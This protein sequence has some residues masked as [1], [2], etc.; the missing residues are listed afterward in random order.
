MMAPSQQSWLLVL[1]VISSRVVNMHERAFHLVY[2]RV[3][4]ASPGYETS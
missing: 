3:N 4:P 2:L 1:G